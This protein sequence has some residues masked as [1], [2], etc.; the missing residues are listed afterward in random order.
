MNVPPATKSGFPAGLRWAALVWLA[1]WVAVYWRAW[2]AANFLHLCDIAVILTSFGL[3]S[4]NRLLLSSQA[5]SSLLADTAWALDAGWRYFLGRHLL[6]GTEY[7]FDTRHP[8]WL[9]L[10][11]LYHLLTPPL[12]L[13]ALHRTGYDRRAWRLQSAITLPALIASRFVSPGDNINFAFTD[14]F[15][16]RAWAPAPAYLA[17]IFLLMVFA[18]YLPTHLLLKHLFPPPKQNG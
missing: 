18:A 16:H 3:W 10:L 14:P 11:S 7:L 9:R 13:W 4:N 1:I 15:F 8:L 5:V 6:G 12:L 17:V 2:G